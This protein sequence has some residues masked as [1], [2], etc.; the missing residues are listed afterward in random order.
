MSENVPVSVLFDM[1]IAG[2]CTNM[3]ALAILHKLVDRGEARLLATTACYH[4]PYVA[5]CIDALNRHYGHIVPVGTLHRQGDTEKCQFTKELCETFES[6]YPV[7]AP[8][9]DSVDVM[10]RALS[11]EPDGSVKLVICGCLASAAALLDSEPDDI[12][13]LSGRELAA[14]KIKCTYVMGGQFP[15]YND[16]PF[17]EAN[18]RFQIPAAQKFCKEWPGQVIFSGYEIGCRVIS[19]NN[20]TKNGSRSNPVNMAYRI[21]IG[22]K[23]GTYSW[24][25]T[26]VLAAVRPEAG[27]WR[28]HENGRVVVSDI[29]RTS[30]E[31]DENGR[32]AYLLPAY[33]PDDVAKIIDELIGLD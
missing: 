21:H 20:F 10:R 8:T 6:A 7:G 14:K 16:T 2:D 17:S 32:Q 23:N 24:D 19:F 30:W 11:G 9:E 12:S 5:G 29:G 3:G 15:T 31:P 4:S 27:Y 1:D 18:I 28:L 33:D 25:H 13:P 22:E 26:A